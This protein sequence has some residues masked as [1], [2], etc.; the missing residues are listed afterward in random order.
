MQIYRTFIDRSAITDSDGNK[1]AG[2]RRNNMYNEI[3]CAVV[4]VMLAST[5]AVAKPLNNKTIDMTR[6]QQCR[7]MVGAEKGEG[8]AGKTHTMRSQVMRWDDCMVGREHPR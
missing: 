6:A 4:V 8:E 1:G 7:Q 5:V 2:N 3:I